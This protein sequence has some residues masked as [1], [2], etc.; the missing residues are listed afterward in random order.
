[1][2][3]VWHA[4]ADLISYCRQYKSGKTIGIA[5]IPMVLLVS[6]RCGNNF[7]SFVNCFRSIY[8]STST[9]PKVHS[10]SSTTR[11]F[12]KNLPKSLRYRVRLGYAGVG[13]WLKWFHVQ[14]FSSPFSKHKKFKHSHLITKTPN[15]LL[16]PIQ[17]PAFIH[18]L[19]NSYLTHVLHLIEHNIKIGQNNKENNYWITWPL[20]RVHVI[21]SSM[22]GIDTHFFFQL[23]IILMGHDPFGF[24]LDL[25]TQI[26]FNHIFWH[27]VK[28][29]R[30][31]VQLILTIY[32]QIGQHKNRLVQVPIEDKKKAC[33]HGT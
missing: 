28:V 30:N 7:Y 9:L 3:Y 21:E 12:E 29:N 15:K 1:M 25:I 10:L 17:L 20:F 13:V 16:K 19:N 31:R 24:I 26:L 23:L 22:T 6:I 11:N 5:S 32:T 2:Q 33:N 14:K 8:W 4:D 18:R 27:S